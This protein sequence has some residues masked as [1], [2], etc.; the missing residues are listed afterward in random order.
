[1]RAWGAAVALAAAAGCGG[2]SADEEATLK[3][4]DRIA[5]LFLHYN[6]SLQSGDPARLELVTSDLQRLAQSHFDRVLAGAGSA[7]PETQSDA[8]FALGFSRN[9][10]AVPALVE[11]T[12]SP[13][14]AVRAN[15][16]AS[17][18]M[19]GFDDLP[20]EPF[21]KLLED[22]E[23]NVRLAV[24]FGLRKLVSP[25][26]DRGLLEPIHK[27]LGDS[28]MDVRNEAVLLLGKIRS[29]KSVAPIVAGPV[30]DREPRV[31][32][33]AAMALR[34]LGRQAAP[35]TPHLIEM[36]RDDYPRVVEE[37]RLALNEIHGTDLDRSYHN[38][39]DWY[40]DEL[41]HYYTCPRHPSLSL[42][43]PGVCPE[44]DCGRKLD[45][46]PREDARKLEPPPAPPAFT[47]ADHP[48]V[49]VNVPTKCG[50]CGK[51]LVVKKPEP[52]PYACPDHPDNVV[53]AP[54]KCG[55]CGKDLVPQ[56]K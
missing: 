4:F 18:G 55:K 29:P 39:R 8:A 37:A 38:W 12:R 43:A 40:E 15:A 22:P 19:L 31:R 3:L 48:E 41:R 17:L 53:G 56:K 36:L 26:N 16:V 33:N 49:I 32:L 42:P 25:E 45:R 1:M 34:L 27:R 5:F 35:A 44:A 46:L 54:A 10:K 14:P 7:D 50:K 52:V 13:E 47:C 6:N 9:A 20:A 11:L 23:P 30:R 51:D 2:R 28:A 24:L 21:Q